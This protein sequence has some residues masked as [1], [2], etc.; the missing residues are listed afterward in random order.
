MTNSDETLR[1]KIQ[2]SMREHLESVGWTEGNDQKIFDELPNMWRKLETDGL[3]PEIKA[4]GM[5]FQ[6][7][8]ASAQNKYREVK[9]MEQMQRDFE[10]IFG[11][12]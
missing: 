11:R 12:R 1:T 4:K 9:I 7:F 8:V 5:T 10:N 3:M 6:H 2:K